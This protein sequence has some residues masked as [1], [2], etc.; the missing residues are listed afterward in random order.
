MRIFYHTVLSF[1][2]QEIFGIDGGKKI[3]YTFNLEVACP[4]SSLQFHM[5]LWLSW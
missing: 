2:V 5:L 3:C 4:F 1:D